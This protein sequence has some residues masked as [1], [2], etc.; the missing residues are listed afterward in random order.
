MA[1]N[2]LI[3]RLTA[4]SLACLMFTAVVAQETRFYPFTEVERHRRSSDILYDGILSDV[5]A[6]EAA[7]QDQRTSHAQNSTSARPT[8][9][10]R[11]TMPTLESRLSTELSR[12]SPIMK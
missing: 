12:L 10:C 7:H 1:H 11:G 8:K 4:L 9:F 2:H 6:A 3:R 5:P